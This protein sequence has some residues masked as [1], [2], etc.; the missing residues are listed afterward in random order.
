MKKIIFT[1]IISLLFTATVHGQ[2]SL[3][4]EQAM[5]IAQENSPALRSSFLNLER[6]KQMLIAQ[7][8]ALKSNFSL[9]LSPASYSN[10]RQFDTRLS[11]WYT[12]ENFA[13]SGT[14]QVSQPILKTD[15][16]IS[17]VNNFGWQ[18][19]TSNVDGVK[20][21]NDAFTNNLNLQ[22]SQPVFTYNR[23]K[24]E[25]KQLEFNLENA[26]ISYALQ[27]LNTERQITSQ[28]YAVYTAQSNVTIS[29][30]EFENVQASYEIIK[31]KVEADLAVKDEL[32][33]AELN[34]ATARS[35]VDAS[36]VRLEN[37]KDQLKQTLGLPL[38][39]DLEVVAK[40]VIKPVDVDLT[41]A[42]EHGLTSRLELR[43]REISGEE[44]EFDL[45][46]T[47]AL[48]EFKGDISLSLGLSGDNR[49]FSKIYENP[50]QNPRV[51]I[52]FAI[53]IFD[54]GEKKA[55]IKAQKISQEVHEINKEE[56]IKG[57]ELDIRQVWRSLE[58]LRTQIS[59]VEQSV[60]NAQLA[61][62]LNLTRYREGDITGMQINQFQTQLSSKKMEY[63]QALI[64]YKLELLNLKILSLFD[65]E[66]NAPIVPM[67][68]L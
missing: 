24:M 66:K 33:Q 26:N 36:I 67:K 37:A 5:D 19:N 8:A 54:W 20:N 53:P 13:T 49:N 38:G 1:T 39:Q 29:K 22:I 11:Q 7:R 63:T 46:R 60:R 2:L 59:I 45:I 30:D 51:A 25:L 55:R 18:T 21:Y 17:L 9:N 58:N 10:R 57:I 48:N 15:G 62:E 34:L 42:I 44:L 3:T 47:K 6:Y 4:I 12:N 14:F 41:M 27:R 64:N 61:Y 28:F 16:V 40:V 32:Y 68:G 35:S 52:T 65:F 56:E 50:V 23:R 43:Q 31:N